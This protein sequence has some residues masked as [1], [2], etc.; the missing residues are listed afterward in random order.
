[1]RSLNAMLYR[2]IGLFRRR[3][4]EA[5]MNAEIQSHLDGLTERNIA[6]GLPPEEARYAA[7]RAFGGVAQIA[8]QARDERHIVWIEQLGQDLRY[9]V[10]SL[11]KSPSFTITAVLTLALGIG[12][13]AALFSV[14]NMVTLRSLPVKDPDSLVRVEGRNARGNGI[15]GFN[16]AE[17]VAY[18]DGSRTLDGLLASETIDRTVPLR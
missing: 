12:V 15:R 3:A 7:L 8:E 16:S 18:R 17:Y 13:N 6:A 11:A 4:L 2:V 10:R 9:A 1:M 5:E 14:V